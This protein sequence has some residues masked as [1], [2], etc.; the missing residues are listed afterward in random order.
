VNQH[1]M[2]I[3]DITGHTTVTWDPTDA[4]SVRDARREF[5]RLVREGYA[6]FRMNVVAE[7][8]VV[9]EQKD[10]ERIREFDPTAGKLMMVPHRQGG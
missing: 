4:A 7:N 8:G 10:S 3:M 6:A 2:S 9:V 1:V 5:D